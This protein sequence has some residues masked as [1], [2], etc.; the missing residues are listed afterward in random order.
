MEFDNCR[1][2]TETGYNS[3]KDF[4]KQVNKAAAQATGADPYAHLISI[5]V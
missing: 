2:V 4:N 3:S 5:E 1:L